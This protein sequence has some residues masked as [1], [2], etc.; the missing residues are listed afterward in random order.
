M[1][2]EIPDGAVIVARAIINSSL[3]KMRSE[4]RIV[5]ITCLALANKRAKK[6][7]N[8]VKQIVIQRG[9]FVR[10]REEMADECGLPLQVVRTSIE[11]LEKSEFL[12]RFLTRS[13]TLYTVPKYQHYQD[14]TK[15]SDSGVLKPTRFLTRSQP[16]KTSK[17]NPAI[18]TDAE[19]NPSA[20]QPVASLG[21]NCGN[22]LTRE[23][24]KTNH[25]QQH[26]TIHPSPSSLLPA[27]GT[28]GE[29]NDRG[30]AVVV[31][32]GR[33]P[34]PLLLKIC[35]RISSGLLISI[36]MSESC[37]NAFASQ[38]PVGQ[39]LRV[40]QH[41][42][43][44]KRPGGW[45]RIALESDW[46]LPEASGEEL[47]EVIE[48]LKQDVD[49]ANSYFL[50]KTGGSGV[51]AKLPER[52]AGEDERTWMRRVSDEIS[53]RREESSGSKKRKG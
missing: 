37:A 9:Q 23:N 10:S 6:W 53:R 49:R 3:W 38:K 14:L 11:H 40:V 12:T 50:K 16:G 51:R 5:A 46:A 27:N 24:G 2:A 34:D 13:Y 17:S 39:V 44:Q 31:T 22:F 25:K 29:G 33:E 52:L 7:F 19:R 30:V 18:S 42:R 4:D 43:S 32:S 36:G 28:T 48:K 45:A 20:A 41:A 1:G 26:Q 47:R 8:G 35:F 15:Y 21:I